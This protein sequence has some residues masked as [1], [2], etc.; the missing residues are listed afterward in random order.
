MPYWCNG[1]LFDS[2]VEDRSVKIKQLAQLQAVQSSK[3]L[4]AVVPDIVPSSVVSTQPSTS[5]TAVA[6][7][8]LIKRSAPTP[9]PVPASML[10]ALAV[11]PAA[12]QTPAASIKRLMIIFTNISTHQVVR[13]GLSGRSCRKKLRRLFDRYAECQQ[14]N[15]K[16]FNF[17]F[18]GRLLDPTMRPHQAGLK[19]G[20]TIQVTERVMAATCS[21]EMS[22]V[23]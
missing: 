11:A 7:D 14:G 8:Q 5:V 19:D 10:P 1:F 21:K 4:L 18:Q 3:A 20:D 17:T 13:I 9:V 23:Q 16:H 15:A 2:V 12:V 22:V 6:D